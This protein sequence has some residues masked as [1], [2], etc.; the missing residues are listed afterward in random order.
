MFDNPENLFVAGFIGTPPMNFY[1]GVI[2]PTCT[3]FEHIS[4]AKINLNEHQKSVLAGYA[5]K[6][7]IMASR[8]EY[9]LVDDEALNEN[10][11][12]T[13]DFVVDYS[14]Y[15]GAYK[16]VYGTFGDELVVAKVNP[17]DKTDVPVLKACFKSEKIHFFDK[18]TTKR[19]R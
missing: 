19:I 16:L 14:E 13:F 5:G 10:K 4:G 12:Q 1:N 18:E 17:K 11:E 15:L 8:P 6:N 2:D 7:V 9:V 3:Y